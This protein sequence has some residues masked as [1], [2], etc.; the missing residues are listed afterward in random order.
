MKYKTIK[1]PKLTLLG[2]KKSYENG[3]EAQ[4]HIADFWRT[5]FAEG[6]ISKL[7]A[8]NN[9]DFDGL[10][11]ICIPELDG[12]MSYMIAVTVTIDNC[13]VSDD[14]ELTTLPSLTYF[15]FEAQGVVPDAVQLKMEEVHNYI[16]KY[17][18][19]NIRKAPF[20]EYYQEGDTSSEQYITELWVPINE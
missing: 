17:H 3:R 20:F 14:F 18:G 12:K 5:C 9:G 4:Q 10:L 2:I 8:S 15:V 6:T 1:L 13:S 7:Q 11:G 19:D 16:H